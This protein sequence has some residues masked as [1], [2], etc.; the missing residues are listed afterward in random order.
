MS[1]RQDLPKFVL[2]RMQLRAGKLTELAGYHVL[3]D[4]PDDA[5]DD[6]GI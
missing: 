1:E 2:D 4:R 5:G 3:F 6:W